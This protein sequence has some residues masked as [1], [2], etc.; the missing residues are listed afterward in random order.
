MTK[1][2]QNGNVLMGFK[3]QS[4]VDAGYFYAPYIPVMRTPVLFEAPT[5]ARVQQRAFELW[6]HDANRVK[7]GYKDAF[8]RCAEWYW[9]KAQDEL[10][11]PFARALADEA[12]DGIIFKP[13]NEPAYPF[14][15]WR[16]K[17]DHAFAK[18]CIEEE[19]LII[20]G[21]GA[22]GTRRFNLHLESDLEE[23]LEYLRQIQRATEQL[24]DWPNIKN[25]CA[26]L[27]L[28]GPAN[29]QMTLVGNNKAWASN[30]SFAPNKG[31][32][33]RYGK[34]LLQ[35]GAQYYSKV[36]IGESHEH[37]GDH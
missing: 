37:E 17:N 15:Y 22:G 6:Q 30:N 19:A 20:H 28:D 29:E 2:D 13:G 5:H 9:N 32:L 31:I 8:E 34:K 35:Q 24:H 26:E 14:E 16:Y 10:V 11:S 18:A 36:R 27:P 25:P 1:P 4:V 21:L 23:A 3:G 7:L 12:G 33:T